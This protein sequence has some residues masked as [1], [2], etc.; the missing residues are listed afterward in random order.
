MSCPDSNDL[1][2]TNLFSALA[3]GD[4]TLPN[5]VVMAPMTR[6]RAG[7]GFVPR[8]LNA[9]YYAQRATA[10]LIISEATQV[11]PEGI[12]YPDTPG[13]Y[14]PEQ[15]AGWRRV[16][17]AV[18]A[19]GGRM[20]AQLWHVGRI[21]H[22]SLQPAGELPVA[23]SAIKPAGEA[24]TYAGMVP[25]VTPRALDTDEIPSIVEQYRHGAECAKQAGFDGIEVHAANG[26]LLDQFLR[27]GTNQRDDRYGGRI[28]NRA[29]LTLEVLEAVLQVW[30]A[31]RVGIRVSP[32]STFND[33]TDSEPK[34]TFGY[35]AGALNRYGPAYLHVVEG[36]AAP[37]SSDH[38][39][40]IYRGVLMVNG[41]YDKRR[42]NAVVG[43]GTADLVS[44]GKRF[45]ANPDLPER[46]RLDAPLNDADKATFYGGGSKGYTDYPHLDASGGERRTAAP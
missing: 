19:E 17:D 36:N 21:S 43:S 6:N 40:K 16:T 22:P 35:L 41:N 14:T 23:P 7:K 8:D 34:T 4:L 10:A 31:R 3:I 44:F 11:A 37:V 45:L 42:A 2:K 1:P 27:D 5:R 24:M 26:Y 29:R 38:L 18:H 30:P 28:E 39:R 32:N 13:I 20:F 12:G 15:V 25:F 46:L 33:M 9:T